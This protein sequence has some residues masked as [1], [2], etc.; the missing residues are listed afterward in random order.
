MPKLIY[1]YILFLITLLLGARGYSQ[2]P[3]ITTTL[4]PSF[5]DSC[6]SGSAIDVVLTNNSVG[7]SGPYD[8]DLFQGSTFLGNP[9][10]GDQ[11]TASISSLGTTE[12]TLIY[13]SGG[14]EDTTTIEVNYISPS[15]AASFTMSD[16]DNIVCQG[17]TI[18]FN[19]NSIGSVNSY[20]WDFGNGNTASTAGPHNIAYN[21]LGNYTIS[22]TIT[23]SCGTDSYTQPLTVNAG[24]GIT[25]VIDGDDGT[26]DL[27]NCLPFNSTTTSQTVSFTNATTGASSY[28]WD[29][30]DGTPPQTFNNT[31]PV[32]HTYNTYGSFTATMTAA[33]SGCS[34]ID[35]LNVIF[36]RNPVAALDVVGGSP[37]FGCEPYVVQPINQSLNGEQ[38]IW[39]FGD[40]TT[41]DT[42]VFQ[43]PSNEYADGVFVI[44]LSTLNYCDTVQETFAPVFVA[45][46]PTANFSTSADSICPGEEVVFYN[47]SIDMSPANNFMWDLGDGTMVNDILVPDTHIYNVPGVYTVELIAGGFCGNDTLESEITV[48]DMPA[49]NFNI[50][51]SSGCIPGPGELVVNNTSAGQSLRYEWYVNNNLNSS[52]DTLNEDFFLP[53]VLSYDI[54]LMAISPC[55]TSVK[56]IT[57]TYNAGAQANFSL[58]SAG[59]CQDESVVFTDASLG[60]SLSYSWD[61]GG[62]NTATTEGPHTVPF[63][64]VGVL[65]IQLIVSGVCGNDTVIKNITV[66]E[67]PTSVIIPDDTEICL[68]EY[69]VFENNSTPGSTF[70]WTFEGGNPGVFNALK[71]DSVQF[72]VDGTNNVQLISTLNGCEDT[73]NVFIVVRNKP[74]VNFVSS[75]SQGCSPLEVGFANGSIATA[76]NQYSWNFN[77]GNTSSLQDPLSELFINN[78]NSVDSI[79]EVTLTVQNTFG[80]VDS[81]TKSITVNPLPLAGFFQSVDTACAVEPIQFTDTSTGAVTYTW[82]FGDNSSSAST[83]PVHLYPGFGNYDVTQ[84]IFNAQGCADTTVSTVFIDSVPEVSFVF[85]GLCL[86]DSTEFE[87]TT[88]GVTS[89]VWNFDDGTILNNQSNPKNKF[90]TEGTYNVSLVGSNDVGCTDTAF[91]NVIIS[92]IP[93]A[94]FEWENNCFGEV[95]M[96]ADTSLNN[97]ID[98]EWNFGDGST[99][100]LNPNPSHS[101]PSAGTYDIQLVVSNGLSCIDT[102]KQT[103]EI[104]S[105]PTADFTFNNVCENDTM[106][107]SNTSTFSPDVFVWNFGDGTIIAS[108]TNSHVFSTGNNYN[109]TLV[110]G[111]SQSQCYDTVSKPIEIYTRAIPDFTFDTAC[112]L[113]ETAFNDETTNN[114][115]V[116][117]WKFGDSGGSISSVQ[118]PAYNYTDGVG[119]YNATLI[120]ETVEGC[121]DSVNKSVVVNELPTSAFVVDSICLKTSTTLTNNSSADVVAWNWNFGDGGLSSSL[122]STTH[123]YQTDGTFNVQL[124]VENSFGCTD[125]SSQT[126]IVYELPKP[127]FVSDT[128]C[129]LSATMLTDTSQLATSWEYF[130]NDGSGTTSSLQN[131]NYVFATSGTFNVKQIV[132]SDNQCVDSVTA[133]VVVKVRPEASFSY[134]AACA[135]DSTFFTQ[136]TQGNVIEWIWNY[137][138]TNDL[139]TSENGAFS[140][141]T[142]GNYN[143]S[144]FVENNVG[145]K[146]TLIEGITAYT[147]PSANFVADTVCLGDITTFQNTSSDIYPLVFFEWS[148]GDNINTSYAESPT[149]IYQDSGVFNVELI[150]TNDKGCDTSFFKDVLVKYT[151][152]VDFTA[153]TVCAGVPTTFNVS[154]S[155]LSEWIWDYGDATPLDTTSDNP[156]Q[157]LYAE[158]GTYFVSLEGNTEGC[159]DKQFKVVKVNSTVEAEIYFETACFGELT[160]FADSSEVLSGSISTSTWNFNDGTPQEMGSTV[161]HLFPSN[162]TFNVSLVVVTDEGCSDS[163]T[164]EVVLNALPIAGFNL[165]Q[166]NYCSNA[167]TTV[168]DTSQIAE[169]TIVSWD[170]DFGDGNIANLPISSNEY[171]N[172]GAYEIKLTVTSD[173][174]CTDSIV[175][176]IE[177]FASPVADFRNNVT[178]SNGI[179]EFNDL[180]TIEDP[181]ATIDEWFWNFGDGSLDSIASPEHQYDLLVDSVLAQ[182]VVVSNQ[183]CSDTINQFVKFYPNPVLNFRAINAKGCAPFNTLFEDQSVVPGV[184]T[185]TNWLWDFGDGLFSLEQNP[186]HIYSDSGAYQVALTVTTSTGCNVKDTLDYLVEVEPAPLV[187]FTW[188]PN[189]REITIL[190]PAIELIDL[191]LDSNNMSA[192]IIDDL[193]SLPSEENVY[194]FIDTGV[195][196]ITQIVS[197]PFGC[198]N[199]LTKE[200]YIAPV[201]TFYI[202]TAFSPNKDGSNERFIGTGMNVRAMKMEIYNRGGL[203]IFESYD[204]KVGWDGTA[205]GTNKPMPQAAYNYQIFVTD[206][207]GNEHYFKDKV[208][209]L[210]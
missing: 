17:S 177:V 85:E 181:T 65:P 205:F 157:H 108:D 179:T 69:V 199:S 194:T 16:A 39:D 197:N 121:E 9:D 25:T 67:S 135:K 64:S 93:E 54:K 203:L 88:I 184:G 62:G 161:E 4:T 58:S 76:G 198:K 186:S 100:D 124:V 131:P 45:P 153:D 15:D 164:A 46:L 166:D 118:N 175:D 24:T 137:G 49:A 28:V 113:Q 120:V 26:G 79:Y 123:L 174:G 195:H 89:F 75:V 72:N 44:T 55:D 102:L 150:V 59:I 171:L 110:A 109:V 53:G 182:L 18:E 20:A 90:L 52:V 129:Y 206:I 51:P 190:D 192:W 73:S 87:E 34:E 50:A 204:S 149:Y 163:T 128:A 141:E 36:G 82:N 14:C 30:G 122:G 155:N 134:T 172:Y 115:V 19:D 142:G 139:D 114:P 138:V 94:G 95:V 6:G 148:F 170:W 200:I 156:N 35:S 145:C 61:F 146:D 147:R 43:A 11:V 209:L 83:N 130:F 56:E 37:V 167:I 68:G 1:T 3:G 66:K 96:F 101:F 42:N 173:K 105:L 38:Y 207:W 74:T 176:Q 116:W 126:A 152:E 32:T 140:Y 125:T 70:N 103:I 162:D 7:P 41:I 127:G 2:C 57:V 210:R 188:L 31:N 80:C 208:I 111:Y 63:S 178:C 151:P 169:G 81:V 193:E 77:N 158:G 99:V 165:V 196:Q 10:L 144:L 112:Y 13:I 183:G 8:F 159:S 22:L 143:V 136:N 23:G 107:F 29:F 191:Q 60:N 78:S 12:F 154:G 104:D 48:Y 5:V 84:V 98:W 91:Q 33:N 119:V 133:L 185:V 132:T 40:A 117:K 202:P 27:R 47:A 92:P 21:T 189:D 201:F 168:N 86:G 187:D 97:P 106:F 71:P 180:S 160:S